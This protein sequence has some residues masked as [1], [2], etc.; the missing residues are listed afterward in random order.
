MTANTNWNLLGHQWAVDLLRAQIAGGKLRHAYLLTGPRGLGRRTLTTRLAQAVNCESAPTAGEF[1]GECRACRG[2]ERMAHPDL[3]LLELQE[4]DREIKVDAVRELSRMLAL[5]P[6]EAPYQVALLREFEAASE[7]AANALLKT[8]EEPSPNVLLLITAASAEALPATIAS[9]C[10]LLRLRPVPLDE[11][12]QGLSQRWGIEGEQ[13]RLLA[14]LSGGRPGYA[15]RLHQDPEALEQRGEWLETAHELV[16]AGRVRRFAVAEAISKDREQVQQVLQV[17]LSFWRD[18]LLASAHSG[19]PLANIDRQQQVD[20]LS[21][22]LDAARAGSAV[23][24]IERTLGLL[25]D[26]NV[27]ARLAVESLLLELPQL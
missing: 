2:F 16:G 18:I 23:A 14:S 4:G 11:L 25:A 17:W 7:S 5:T 9:R 3:H 6:Y 15:L 10:E 1:C 22:R 19:L 12:A 8:L 24:A 13:A 27:N 20:A 26:T 21:T